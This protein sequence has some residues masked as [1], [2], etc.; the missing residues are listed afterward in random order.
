MCPGSKK[1]GRRCLQTKL[2]PERENCGSC[3]A[4][5]SPHP[6]KVISCLVT[7]CFL[8]LPE[9][10]GTISSTIPPLSIN[11]CHQ[12]SHKSQVRSLGGDQTSVDGGDAAPH[13]PTQEPQPCGALWAGKNVCVPGPSA[14]PQTGRRGVH[15]RLRCKAVKLGQHQA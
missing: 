4:K 15:W 11:K 2:H 8:P 3:L 12:L 9:L 13:C 1:G 10:V 7:N 5:T 14:V 6:T